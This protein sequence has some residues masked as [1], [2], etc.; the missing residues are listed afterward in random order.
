MYD[1]AIGRSREIYDTRFLLEFY[2]EHPY[3][4]E[5]TA[6]YSITESNK[7]LYTKV[8]CSG[9]IKQRRRTRIDARNARAHAGAC[10][11]IEKEFIGNSVVEPVG[12]PPRHGNVNIINN[13]SLKHGHLVAFLFFYIASRNFFAFYCET[14]AIVRRK[15]HGGSCTRKKINLSPPIA[16]D[17][18]PCSWRAYRC[19]DTRFCIATFSPRRR[20]NAGARFYRRCERRRNSEVEITRDR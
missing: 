17:L 2:A 19:Y 11:Q 4:V 12:S 10:M 6:R 8:G 13:L 15:S 18:S 7:R 20:E 1:K 9:R 5:T 16:G 14:K 3:A